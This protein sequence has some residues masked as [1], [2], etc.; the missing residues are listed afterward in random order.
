M[1]LTRKREIIKMP[2]DFYKPYRCK[3]KTWETYKS[4]LYIITQK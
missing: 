2:H 4:Y 1:K 3:R